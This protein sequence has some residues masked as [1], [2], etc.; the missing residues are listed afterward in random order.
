[1]ENRNCLFPEKLAVQ[2][3]DFGSP[4]LLVFFPIG[5]EFR[6][7]SCGDTVFGLPGSGDPCELPRAA[8]TTKP[9]LGDNGHKLSCKSK[10]RTPDPGVVRVVPLGL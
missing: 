2:I 8:V 7:V 3:T 4:K 10:A 1:M 9:R 6:C 5:V